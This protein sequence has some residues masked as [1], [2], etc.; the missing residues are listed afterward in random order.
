LAALGGGMQ[1]M[2]V[3][4]EDFHCEVWMGR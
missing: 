4:P 3:H 1:E 2:R